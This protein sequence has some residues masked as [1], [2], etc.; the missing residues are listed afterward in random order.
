MKRS[1]KGAVRPERGAVQTKGEVTYSYRLHKENGWQLYGNSGWVEARERTR[2]F[3]PLFLDILKRRPAISGTVAVIFQVR[4]SVIGGIPS[5]STMITLQQFPPTNSPEEAVLLAPAAYVEAPW[6]PN[7]EQEDLGKVLGIQANRQKTLRRWLEKQDWT[8]DLIVHV[9]EL[10]ERIPRR[11]PRPE[12]EDSLGEVTLTI[13]SGPIL[14]SAR[15]TCGP[16]LFPP[17]DRAWHKTSILRKC[18][19]V[20]WLPAPSRF[21]SEERCVVYLFAGDESSRVLK[22]VNGV[23]RRGTTRN[24]LLAAKPGSGKE[25]VARLVHFGRGLGHFVATSAAGQEWADFQIPLF[26]QGQLGGGPPLFHGHIEQ[27]AGGTLFIDE[28]D[29][30]SRGLRSGLLRVIEN[31]EFHRPQSWERIRLTKHNRPLFMFAGSGQG[32]ESDRVREEIGA[33]RER[34]DQKGAAAV[35]QKHRVSENGPADRWMRLEHPPDFWDRIDTVIS[36][37]KPFNSSSD[38]LFRDYVELFLRRSTETLINRRSRV[39]AAERLLEEVDAQMIERVR[40]HWNRAINRLV[41]ELHD[42]PK[43]RFI[44]AATAEFV[45]KLTASELNDDVR[46]DQIDEIAKES[47]EKVTGSRQA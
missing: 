20:P 34:G 3:L 17:D 19:C 5:T 7:T 40:R 32:T 12:E 39:Y 25:V 42:Y 1:A 37:A 46:A 15:E 28:I 27:A 13:K 23:W 30:A 45:G 16:G 18:F 38:R 24:L 2:A 44:R 11:P 14:G 10:D 31:D 21:L 47:V 22:D 43:L 36:F 35:E 26:G 4:K 41:A 9:T 29:K 33:A 8:Y 6:V